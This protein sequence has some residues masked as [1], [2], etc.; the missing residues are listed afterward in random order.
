[1]FKSKKLKR[2]LSFITASVICMFAFTQVLYAESIPYALKGTMGSLDTLTG[3][4]TLWTSGTNTGTINIKLHESAPGAEFSSYK[5]LNVE[6][7]GGVLKVS[8]P[9]EAQPF[10]KHYCGASSEVTIKDIKEKLAEFPE[11]ADKSNSIVSKFLSFTGSK[12][13]PATTG[14]VNGVSATLR[15]EFGFYIIQQT[16]AP[17]DGYI[18][19]AP[20]LACLPMQRATDRKWLSSYTAEPKDDKIEVSKKVKAPG[21][22]DYIKETIAEIG[23]QLEYEIV[24]DLAKYGSDITNITYTLTDELPVGIEYEDGSAEVKFYKSG[25]PGTPTSPYSVTYNNGTRTLTLDLGTNYKNLADFDTAKITYRATLGSSAIIE[26]DGNENGVNLSYTYTSAVSDTKNITAEAKVYTHELDITKVDVADT[27]AALAGAVFEVYRSAEDANAS[28]NKI[29]FVLLDTSGY[30]TGKHYRVATATD[31]T[32][33]KI[34]SISVSDAGKMNIYGLDDDT[35]YFKEIVAPTGYNLPDGPFA[36]SPKPEDSE[37]TVDAEGATIYQNMT[38]KAYKIT[39]E[40]DINLPVTGG[41]GTII[42]TVA[43]LLLMVGAAYVLF[44]SKKKSN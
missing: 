41:I 19:S 39:N 38:A 14:E 10:W 42:F 4:D 7:V 32:T 35:Y 31:D 40:S 9:N 33:K 18:A 23:D 26:G 37:K 2:A 30:E 1:M 8:I 5:L 13:G 12:P 17:G 34:T 16:K 20:I 3:G 21:D 11:D 24:V 29:E 15:S 27:N 22:T 43:G 25:V 44:F 6:N 36:I 28:I